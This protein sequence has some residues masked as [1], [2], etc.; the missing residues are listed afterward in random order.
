MTESLTDNR[1]S[2][3]STK[4]ALPK[5]TPERRTASFH[6]PTH[7]AATFSKHR[8]SPSKLTGQRANGSLSSPPRAIFFSFPGSLIT[9]AQTPTAH[10]C[11][12][13]FALNHSI[14]ARDAQQQGRA[15]PND[16]YL[17]RSSRASL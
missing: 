6:L 8:F 7:R 15:S 5:C 14:T 9:R 4:L 13:R 16:D 10:Q 12:A 3:I 1:F 2:P 11:I 17:A